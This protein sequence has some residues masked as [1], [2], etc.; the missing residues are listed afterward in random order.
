MESMII[1]P[2]TGNLLA[3]ISLVGEPV[4]ADAMTSSNGRL[5][6]YVILS[7]KEKLWRAWVEQ[8]MVLLRT[9]NDQRLVRIVTYPTDNGKQGYLDIINITNES[10][11]PPAQPQT[12]AS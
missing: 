9:A 12:W 11:A 7:D 4:L 2:K 1:D 8:Q 3:Q 10:D 5:Q 6:A